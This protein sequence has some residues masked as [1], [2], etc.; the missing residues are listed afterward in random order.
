[1]RISALITTLLSGVA[2]LQVQAFVSPHV[3]QKVAAPFGVGHFNDKANLVQTSVSQDEI[4]RTL[5]RS[6]VITFMGWGP[7]PIWS[8]ATVVSN[9]PACPSTNCVSVTVE[10]PSETLEAYKVPGQYVQMKVSVAD[11]DAK[12]IFLAIASPPAKDEDSNTNTMEFLIKKTDNN[13]WIT[14]ATPSSTIAVSQ[15]LGSG[16][17]MEENL[18]GFKYDFPTQN[19]LLFANGSGIAPIRAAIESGQLKVGPNSGRTARLYYGVSTPSDMPYAE[20]FG[21]WE[22]NG[23]EVVPV[24]SRPEECKL[25]WIGRTG[26]VQNALEEDGVP[27]PRNSGALLCGVK[28]MAE[29]VK[30]LLT[31]AGVFEGRVLTNF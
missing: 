22:Q 27:I 20:K 8:E 25:E 5:Q 13:S 28:G 16:F 9:E 29:S 4:I 17:P 21:K 11:E 12:P 2:T 31:K 1:M 23:V 18:E 3:S 14:S 19:V 7:E 15:V 26:Y 24:V 10:V 30:D 6:R